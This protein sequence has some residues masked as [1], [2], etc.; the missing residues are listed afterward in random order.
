[1]MTKGT[2]A[3]VRSCVLA[4]LVSAAPSTV[5]YAQ[6]GTP[7]TPA[8]QGGAGTGT[9]GTGVAAAQQ[10]GTIGGTGAQQAPMTPN[11]AQTPGAGGAAGVPTAGTPG[12]GYT[13]TAN[14]QLDNTGYNNGGGHGAWGWLG[15]IGLF[16]LLGLRGRNSGPMVT[17]RDETAYETMSGRRT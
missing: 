8:A 10:P 7:G 15:L 9:A 5:L 13:G 6:A 11:G 1:M 12:S 14:G 2:K 3:T 16:G 4:L 17:T